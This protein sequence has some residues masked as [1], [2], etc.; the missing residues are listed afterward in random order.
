MYI[1]G[2]LFGGKIIAVQVC[3][4]TILEYVYRLHSY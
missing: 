1:I 2:M 3:T 4:S